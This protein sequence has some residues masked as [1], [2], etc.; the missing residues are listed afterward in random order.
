MKTLESKNDAIDG[1]RCLRVKEFATLKGVAKQT[2]LGWC[3]K[4]IIPSIKL[5]PKTLMIPLQRAEAALV[6]FGREV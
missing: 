3:R 6:K 4:G 5:G 1:A 2:V